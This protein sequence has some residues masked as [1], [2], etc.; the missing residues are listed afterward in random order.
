M[1]FPCVR[2]YV[3]CLFVFLFLFFL[4][5]FD[6]R[7]FI[8]W[9]SFVYIAIVNCSFLAFLLEFFYN[10]LL[11]LVNS[12]LHSTSLQKKK[13]SSNINDRQ[14]LN[15]LNNTNA[16]TSANQTFYLDFFFDT[17]S[18]LSLV[19]VSIAFLGWNIDQV[20]RKVFKPQPRRW[21]VLD[22]ESCRWDLDR[23]DKYRKSTKLSLR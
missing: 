19:F 14:L 16:N 20:V 6:F 4:A 8:S 12:Q 3:L 17:M 13:K 21:N 1:W 2:S 7:L 22:E 5:L 15:K 23:V 10:N 18:W 11:R 9:L